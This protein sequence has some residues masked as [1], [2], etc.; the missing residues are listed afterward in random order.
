MPLS[1]TFSTLHW[2]HICWSVFSKKMIKSNSEN[3]RTTTAYFSGQL[4]CVLYV[5][6]MFLKF[7]S[8]IS[9]S[10]QTL[11]SCSAFQNNMLTNLQLLQNSL[12]RTF[13]TTY[14]NETDLYALG[15]KISWSSA[16][17]LDSSQYL[18]FHFS[19]KGSSSGV[20]EKVYY[21]F[22]VRNHLIM[23][24]H[25]LWRGEEPYPGSPAS[26][27]GD[28]V[29]ELFPDHDSGVPWRRVSST[30]C[31]QTETF[32]LSKHCRSIYT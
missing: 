29:Q 6:F 2:F 32:K 18:L 19:L 11:E 31:C 16:L 28:K 13:R 15:H 20:Y 12:P 25:P 30:F 24:E 23:C 5:W 10:P 7:S 8:E 3:R 14:W 9:F 27:R 1:G 26:P 21:R 22:A 17:N 4:F